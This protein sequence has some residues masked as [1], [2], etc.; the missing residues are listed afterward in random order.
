MM[1]KATIILA[2]IFLLFSALAISLR[3]RWK[4][5]KLQSSAGAVG[6]LGFLL[7][8][9]FDFLK[10]GEILTFSNLGVL[11][12]SGVLVGYALFQ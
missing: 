7:L 11:L 6:A 8:M 2:L 1:E 10:R 5:C 9:L 12:S 3:K 4:N